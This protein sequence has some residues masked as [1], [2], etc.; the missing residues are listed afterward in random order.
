[1]YMYSYRD[2]IPLDLSK[3]QCV[4]GS[5]TF[6]LECNVQHTGL[7]LQSFCSNSRPRYSRLQAP[8][9]M[10]LRRVKSFVHYSCRRSCFFSFIRTRCRQGTSSSAVRVS[11]KII[12]LVHLSYCPGLQNANLIFCCCCCLAV[13]SQ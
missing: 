13:Q 9:N 8:G 5:V 11:F 7:R 3:N 1:M 6:V 12:C 2:Y 4:Q 10:D